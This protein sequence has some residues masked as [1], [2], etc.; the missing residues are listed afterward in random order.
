MTP[1]DL[2]HGTIVQGWLTFNAAG[3]DYEYQVAYWAMVP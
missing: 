3:G 2:A 1:H